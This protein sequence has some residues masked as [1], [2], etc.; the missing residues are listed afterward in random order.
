MKQFEDWAI[1]LMKKSSPTKGFYGKI[2]EIARTTI[3]LGVICMKKLFMTL[4]TGLFM[5]A[6]TTTALAATPTDQEVIAAYQNANKVFEWFS[7]KPLPTNG[8]MKKETG[9]M[10]Y[11]NVNYP[12]V[13]TMGDLHR[14]CEK[15]FT[16]TFSNQLISSSRLYKEFDGGLF[17]AP[18]GRGYNVFAG[19]DSFKVVRDAATPDKLTLQV[20][21][22]KLENPP[23]GKMAVVGYNTHNFSY[24]STPIGWRFANFQAVR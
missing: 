23:A 14:E 20:S 21:T 15:V 7:C 3:K 18:A 17:V 10:I 16:Y 22:E 13:R 19:K 8:R 1:V 24:I 5:L 2:V 9:Y 4:L 12:N 11:Y 6:M